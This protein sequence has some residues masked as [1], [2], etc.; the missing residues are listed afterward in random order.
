MA[1]EAQK[2][3]NVI[4]PMKIDQSE[5]YHTSTFVIDLPKK[6]MFNIFSYKIKVHKVYN[7]LQEVSALEP[8][9]FARHSDCPLKISISSYN[10][11]EMK[12]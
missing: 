12:P 5:E 9:I 10:Y 1:E 4:L 7:D 3:L 6:I 8:E 2:G 11:F